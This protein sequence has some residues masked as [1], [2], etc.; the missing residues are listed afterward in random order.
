VLE[1]DEPLQYLP[2]YLSMSPQ[3]NG[4]RSGFYTSANISPVEHNQLKY[5]N[6]QLWKE[7]AGL[8]VEHNALLFCSQPAQ[9]ETE[10]RLNLQD[11]VAPPQSTSHEG[12]TSQEPGGLTLLL[13]FLRS[14]HPGWNSRLR[15]IYVR[16]QQGKPLGLEDETA[17]AEDGTA[18]AED[19]ITRPWI[20]FEHGEVSAIFQFCQDYPNMNVLME[21]SNFGC[22]IGDIW[23]VLHGA[24]CIFTTHCNIPEGFKFYVKHMRK[25][26]YSSF[27][28]LEDR[29]G[30]SDD[31]IL[32]IPTN[33]RVI[34][35]GNFEEV[36]LRDWIKSTS[37]DSGERML[38]LTPYA[39]RLVGLVKSLY[40]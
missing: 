20:D 12:S 32:E 16:S 3:E 7:T 8:E 24:W 35:Q 18:R 31:Q 26:D 33:C 29:S 13:N 36:L 23:G 17:R 25:Y 40:K 2:Q 14:S 4:Y 6:T 38:D 10:Q 39:D 5:V 30:R 37:T 9:M 15:K 28:I 19:E 34:P 11:T 27:N 21:W 1:Q 22:H